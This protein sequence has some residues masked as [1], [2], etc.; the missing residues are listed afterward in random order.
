[1]QL[2]LDSFG[3]SLRVK[4]KMFW[5]KPSR[6]EGKQIPVREVNAIFLTK[7]IHISSDALLLAIQHNIPV[8]LI[9][10]LGRMVGQVWDGQYGSIATIRKQ[11]ALLATDKRGL[12]WIRDLMV[13][14]L[15]RQRSLLG[16][17][18]EKREGVD[19]EKLDGNMRVIYRMEEKFR[20]FSLENQERGAIEA[21]FRGWEGTA[22][23]H[24][25]VG[26]A[27]L[28]PP[29]YKFKNRSKRP[30]YD[31][32]NA[33]LNYTYAILY[34]QVHLSLMKAGLDPY[35]GILHADQHRKPTLV[36]DVIEVY[37]HWMEEVALQ[38]CCDNL[39]PN[40]AFTVP[41]E[42]TGVW[43]NKPAK[44][45]VV[46]TCLAF[47]NEKVVYHGQPRKRLTH[48]DLDAQRWAKRVREF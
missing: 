32:F 34:A 4:N 12:L 25:L 9:D 30:A 14:K 44:P 38:L 19:V 28:L 40:D 7:G 47:L 16:R 35:M 29:K 6:N 1:M 45:I 11:Q 18:M 24:Y 27:E 17:W 21:S 43:L 36:Y 20:A 15:E 8:L 39:L 13:M 41:D 33:L 42:R 5:V 23:R 31:A 10:G 26:L 2:Y 48:M 46:N 22:S 37:R 3:A